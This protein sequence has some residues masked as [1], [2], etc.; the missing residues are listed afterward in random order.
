MRRPLM[1]C[2]SGGGEIREGKKEGLPSSLVT[3][4]KG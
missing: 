1:L 3:P 4:R 2:P